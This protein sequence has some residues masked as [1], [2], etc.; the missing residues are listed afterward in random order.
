[1][2]NEFTNFLNQNWNDKFK[3]GVTS[4]S[5]HFNAS[6]GGGVGVGAPNASALNHAIIQQYHQQTLRA[7]NSSSSSSAA[8]AAA[9]AAANYENIRLAFMQ[10]RHSTTNAG[11]QQASQHGTVAVNSATAA[12]VSTAT[13]AA[14]ASAPAT[15]NTSHTIQRNPSTTATCPKLIDIHS[16]K[17]NNASLPYDCQS[18]YFLIRLF[19]V[20]LSVSRM[21]AVPFSLFSFPLRFPPHYICVLLSFT[22]CPF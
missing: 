10:H 16:I 7:A 8:A 12:N 5:L 9:A 3:G 14:T 18:K 11:H 6:S 15:T 22:L 19:S 17:G 2:E 20:A 13:A 21:H 1:M 4:S